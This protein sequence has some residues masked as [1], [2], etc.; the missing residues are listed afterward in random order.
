MTAKQRTALTIVA[1]VGLFG[2]ADWY[3]QTRKTIVAATETKTI[4][5]ET[6]TTQEV[7]I[8]FVI[9]TAL[10]T[11]RSSLWVIGDTRALVATHSGRM[12]SSFS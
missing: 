3:A 8:N 1:M 7:A 12:V 5:I 2:H 6:N 10:D 9:D 4:K 11:C